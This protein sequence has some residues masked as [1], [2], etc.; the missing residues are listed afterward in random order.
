VMR[1][2]ISSLSLGITRGDPQQQQTLQGADKVLW[3]RR[4]SPKRILKNTT[5][6]KV[7]RHIFCAA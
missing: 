4:I 6:A 7:T 3:F 1:P 5:T 2:S